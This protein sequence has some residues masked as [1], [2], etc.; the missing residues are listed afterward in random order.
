MG[1]R[2]RLALATAFLLAPVHGQAGSGGEAEPRPAIALALEGGAAKGIA[3]IGLLQWFEEHRIPVD[4]IA[5]TSMGG[6]IGGSY[7]TGLTAD[8]V[9]ELLSSL[10]W[11]ELFGGGVPYPQ[12]H[13]R[14][15]EDRRRYPVRLELGLR[16]GVRLASGLDSG[17]LV[18]LMLSRI[19]FAY[20]TLDSFGDLPIPFRCVATDIEKGEVVVVADGSLAQALRATMAIPAIF[21]PVEREG[22]LLVDGGA[23]N[24]LPTDVAREMGGEIV[25][26]S[27]LVTRDELKD[28]SM[29][30]LAGRA[31]DVMINETVK[32]NLPLADIVVRSDLDGLDVMDWRKL[33]ELFERG[34][35]GAEA[36]AEA[37]LP[38]ALDEAAWREHLAARSARKREAIVEA[39]FAEIVGV[40]QERSERLQRHLEERLVGG[41]LDLD[42]VESELTL[43]VGTGRFESAIYAAVETEDATGLRLRLQEKSHAPPFVNFSADIR[44][45]SDDLVFNFGARMTALDVAGLGSE[46]R[47][48]AAVGSTMGLGTELYWP[49]GHSRVFLAPRLVAERISSNVFQDDALIANVR[50]TRSGAGA[51]LGISGGRRGELRVGYQVAHLDAA[52]RVGDPNLPSLNGREERFDANFVL[53]ALDSAT[54]PGKGLRVRLLGRYYQSVPETLEAETDPDTPEAPPAE[55]SQFPLVGGTLMAAWPTRGED[56]MLLGLRAGTTFSSRPPTLYQFTL[57]GLF[58]LGAFDDDEF[59]GR[60]LLY[61]DLTYLKSL[62]RLPDF[63]GGGIFLTLGGEVGSAFDELDAARFRANGTLGLAMDTA[64]GPIF[65]GVSVGSGGRHNFYLSIGSIGPVGNDSVLGTSVR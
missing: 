11:A 27:H 63:I 34:Y 26:A 55:H 16:D 64:L 56:R 7:A 4:Y 6:L 57:G 10:D 48:D 59:R 19:G 14:R 33:D 43:A 17:H 8:E 46:W 31:I 23:L 2:I 18:G 47:V 38:L 9:R 35:A 3:H 1:V 15:K 60:H 45:Q 5:G 28:A 42:E 54:I 22:R 41:A 25:I 30:G 50:T 12:Q 24:N 39:G 32:R 49:I 58:R 13:F 62:G 36:Q 51:D 53:D 52:V 29:F 21:A 37:L 40:P 44:T 61:A 20:S 65:A